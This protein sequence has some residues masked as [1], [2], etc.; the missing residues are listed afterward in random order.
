MVEERK[1][2]RKLTEDQDIEKL[3]GRFVEGLV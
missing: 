3:V 2:V 1:K